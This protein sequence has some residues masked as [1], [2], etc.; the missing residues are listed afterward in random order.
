VEVSERYVEFAR[1]EA[2]GS[3]ATYERLAIAV[4]GCPAILDR[5]VTLPPIKRQPNLLFA[6]AR[7]LGAP[8]SDPSRFLGFVE[9]NWDDV[10]AV[11]GTHATQTNEAARTGT[12]LP[13]IAA[14]DGPVA[15]IEVGCSAGLCLYPDRYRIAYDHHP[16]LV[17]DS[18]VT[19]DVATSGPVPIPQRL[20]EVVARIGVDLNPIDIS[21]PEG[22]SWLEALIWPEHHH[23]LARLRAAASVVETEPPVLLRGDLVDTIGTALSLVPAAATPIVFHSAV[24]YYVARVDRRRFADQL[25]RHDGVMWISNEAPGVVDDL[26]TDLRPPAGAARVAYFVIGQGGTTTIGI[27]D[28][29][30]SWIRWATPS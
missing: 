18:P 26:T 2:A 12:I 19:I 1:T 16:P 7:I 4:A 14:V 5:L 21:A 8:L 11:M 10:A 27:S 13:L 30:G 20:P 9:S 6:A 28:T 3:S 17:R 29:H 22:R 25:A 23:R 24:L 15:L